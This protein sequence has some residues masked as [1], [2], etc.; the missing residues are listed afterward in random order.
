MRKV[1]IAVAVLIWA[2]GSP[3]SAEPWLRESGGW[4]I[5]RGDEACSM[6]MS[7]E[8]PGS[9]ELAIYTGED[10]EKTSIFVTN[11]GWSIAKNQVMWFGFQVD[12]NLHTM[13]GAG[14]SINYSNGFMVDADAA[15]LQDIA[16]G[17][18][19]TILNEEGLI[20]SLSLKGSSAALAI[21]E[22]CRREVRQEVARRRADEARLAHIPA[23]PFAKPRDSLDELGQ[24]QLGQS[25][26]VLKDRERFL[27]RLNYPSR[28]V[29]AGES[30][31]VGVLV[32]VGGDGLVTDCLAEKSSGSA[33]LDLSAC[34]D[35]RQYARFE[36]AR[37]RNG[38]KSAGVFRTTLR[39]RLGEPVTQD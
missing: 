13:P 17:S 28:A 16:R 27:A 1:S 29:R 24:M 14:T 34:E 22:K 6:S 39:Y 8:G 11:Y 20:D 26:P 25:D 3:G 12:D 7:Y 33:S 19:L 32:L 15:L 10:T 5:V 21:F 23:D 38:L 2:A 30:G 36:P 18:N 37:D 31:E 35:I 4:Q 9:T